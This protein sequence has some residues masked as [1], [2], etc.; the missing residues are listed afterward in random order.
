MWESNI[1]DEVLEH[2]YDEDGNCTGTPGLFV[3]MRFDDF[4]LN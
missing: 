4:N 3:F 1:M 2:P